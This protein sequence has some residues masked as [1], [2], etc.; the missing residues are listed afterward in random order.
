MIDPVEVTIEYLE[1]QS[2]VTALAT[3]GIYGEAI[4]QGERPPCVCVR[5]RGGDQ[6]LHAPLTYADLRIACYA[7]HAPDAR[8]LDLAVREAL[9]V[10]RAPCSGVGLLYAEISEIGDFA[11]DDDWPEWSVVEGAYQV[12]VYHGDDN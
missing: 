4:P 3:G 5:S 11:T 6:A 10:A 7:E 1:A 12:A 2:S 9:D 8:D